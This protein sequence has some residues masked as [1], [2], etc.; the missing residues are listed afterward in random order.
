MKQTEEDICF[1][2]KDLKGSRLRCLMLTGLPD[3][4][5]ARCLSDLVHPYATIDKRNAWMPRGFLEPAEAKLGETPGFLSDKNRD[6]VT[7]WWLSV[8]RSANTPNWDIASTCWVEGR[9]GLLLIEAK[10]HEGELDTTE[11]DCGS[12]NPDNQRQIRSAIAEAK[13][14][15]N[16]DERL[17][18]SG[19]SLSE[20]NCY[21]L[22]NRFA[23][24]WE[25]ARLGV[26]V[27]LVYLGFL[28]AVEMNNDSRTILTSSKQWDDCVLNRSSGIVPPEVWNQKQVINGTPF[29][30][31]TRT[32]DVNVRISAGG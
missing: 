28:N 31:L 24:A 21:Q 3:E 27:I 7:G 15:L 4:R 11:D 20:K 23:W 14:G 8:Q 10:A 16:A 22:S 26:S 2:K 17:R 30:A 29:V 19:W 12:Q 32:L 25:V 9:A 5:V 13:D 6:E 1:K 18:L